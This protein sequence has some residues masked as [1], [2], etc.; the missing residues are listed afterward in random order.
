MTEAIFSLIGVVIGSII[1]WLQSYWT[2]K[3]AHDKN[4]RYLAIRLVC[5]FDKFLEDCAE[6]VRDNGLSLGQ[7][8]AEG[9]LEPQVES[10]GPPIYPDD[11]DW[12]S[13][14]HE[15]MYKILSFPAD[16]ESAEGIIRAAQDI[17]GPPD[18]E[19]WFDERAFHYG[20]FGLAAFALAEELAK[21]YGIRK[22]TYNNWDPVI[23]LKK[24]LSS[25]EARRQKRKELH[26][27]LLNKVFGE[28]KPN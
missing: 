13:I 25:I 23:E 24:A 6:V 4:A 3:R 11:L 20:K 16:V 2:N 28:Q 9:Y 19:E 18:F 14:D 8:T 26:M 5:V 15:L 7:R 21:K 1:S 22:K 27:Q 10:P 17:A 12:K